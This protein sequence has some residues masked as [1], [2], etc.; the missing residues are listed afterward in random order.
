[1]YLKQRLTFSDTTLFVIGD[2]GFAHVILRIRKPQLPRPYRIGGYPVL[3]LV[4]ICFYIRF[5]VQ[6]VSVKPITS[7][8]G[9]ARVISGLPFFLIWSTIGK[10]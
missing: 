5:A 3:P 4:P 10:F 1:M 2:T 9:L 7:N 8:R 6:I